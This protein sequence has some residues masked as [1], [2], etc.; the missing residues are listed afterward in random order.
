MAENRSAGSLARRWA[1]LLR[2]R[3]I[4]NDF[5]VGGLEIGNAVLLISGTGPG[6]AFGIAASISPSR[7]GN[8]L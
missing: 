2:L 3:E 5:K 8:A 7:P 1:S 6:I 4:P